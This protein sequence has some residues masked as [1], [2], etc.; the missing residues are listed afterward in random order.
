MKKLISPLLLGVVMSSSAY[1]L[2][3]N[4]YFEYEHWYGTNSHY[5]GDKFGIFVNFD[6]EAYVGLNINTY[7][8]EK[9]KVLFENV[10][11]DFYE[12]YGGYNF[13]LADNLTLTPSFELR[14]YS[15]G[16][17]K[18]NAVENKP[19]YQV[20][21]VSDSQRGGARYT[22]GL[23]L[24]YQLLENL[25]VHAQYRYEYRTVSRNKREDTKQ[26]Y[27]DNQARSNYEVGL[28]YVPFE[29]WTID[30]RFAYLHGNYV[31]QNEKH[32][33]YQQELKVNY[34]V[35]DELGI[36]LGAEDVARSLHDDKREAKL[37]V[38][39]SYLF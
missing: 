6:D 19:T 35:T 33:D 7:N 27:A 8:Q 15:G 13:E 11:S 12:L 9:N 22:P 14:M 28:S 34:A 21:D 10:V 29:D 31:L 20:G 38:G 25:N 17:Y 30:Y 32:D 18:K 24:S 39:L 5:N 2:D 4:S 26:G 23:K 1:A 16:G 37:K 3:Y 36:Y